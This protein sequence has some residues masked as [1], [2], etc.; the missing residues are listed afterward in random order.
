MWRSPY[1][2]NPE[3]YDDDHTQDDYYRKI[4]YSSPLSPTLFVIDF[5]LTL[6]F[7]D[8]E[9]AFEPH[10]MDSLPSFYTRPFLYQF[11]DFLKSVNKN[12]VLILWT[13]GTRCYIRGAIF[14][15]NIAPYFQKVLSRSDCEKSKAEFGFRK[16]HRY[17]TKLYPSYASMRSVIIDDQAKYNAD[18]GYDLIVNLA[19]YNADR[20]LA[21]IQPTKAV[22]VSSYGDTTLLNLISS[23]R[24]RLFSGLRR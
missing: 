4:N 12:N 13:A 18:D 20:V 19:P 21:H 24:A 3:A 2:V 17:L 6:A 16:S 11:L 5:D 7:Y 15:L 9:Y 1:D 10:P 14:L 8:D 22:T 23:L